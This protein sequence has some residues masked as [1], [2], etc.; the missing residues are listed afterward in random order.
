MQRVMTAVACGMLLFGWAFV[1]KAQE[2]APVQKDVKP[3]QAPT[4]KGAVQAP[5]QKDV[6]PVQAPT[7]KIKP[8]Q[9]PTQKHVQAHVQKPTQKPTQKGGAVQAPTARRRVVRSYR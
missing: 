2:Q 9:A 7:Q 5:V 6:K 4:Q 8:V 3:V 1:A